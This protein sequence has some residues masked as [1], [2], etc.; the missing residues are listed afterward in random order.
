M[1]AENNFVEKS[2]REAMLLKAR[3]KVAGFYTIEEKD[4]RK[5]RVGVDEGMKEPLALLLATGINIDNS[6]WGHYEDNDVHVNPSL[7]P[8]VGICGRLPDREY[9]DKEVAAAVADADEYEAKLAA[10]RIMLSSPV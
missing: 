6:C 7:M 2:K 1:I 5:V 10:R 3:E 8:R 4:G 9:T